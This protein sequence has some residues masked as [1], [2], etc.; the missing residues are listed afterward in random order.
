M[1]PL[2]VA[3]QLFQDRGV[4]ALYAGGGPTLLRE[5]VGN[6][7]YF[8]VYQVIKQA[9]MQFRGLREGDAATFV[10]AGG[11]AGTAYWF[12]IFP[13]DTVKSIVQAQEAHI[14][15]MQVA[16]DLYAKGGVAAF[17][18]GV[19]PA[20]LRAFPACAATWTTFEYSLMALKRL[21]SHC[22]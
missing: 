21:E 16:R 20:M 22:L 1:T 17:Y 11:C 15:G 18:K 4:R 2:R 7:I 14:T 3:R 6:A 9:L 8:T 13:L 19:G 10:V 12:S 5:I